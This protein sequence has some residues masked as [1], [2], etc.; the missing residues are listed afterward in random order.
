M[1]QFNG[2]LFHTLC[3]YCAVEGKKLNTS[4][5]LV[6]DMIGPCVWNIENV[7]KLYDQITTK[8]PQVFS[9]K[10][11]AITVI[12]IEVNSVVNKSTA[13]SPL[14]LSH[15]MEWFSHVRFENGYKNNK[16]PKLN[17]KQAVTVLYQGL[18]PPT[19][20]CTIHLTFSTKYCHHQGYVNDQGQAK[21][22][23]CCYLAQ[24]A[25]NKFKVIPFLFW[26]C[27]SQENW[28]RQNIIIFTCN[29]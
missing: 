28:W 29:C 11:H 23:Q 1:L 27:T 20:S 12:W 9:C 13:N 5:T 16:L 21:N 4:W 6:R 24:R 8:C 18:V 19:S 26:T 10:L 22:K 3:M 7:Y 15:G 14:K 25:I 2:K 17:I